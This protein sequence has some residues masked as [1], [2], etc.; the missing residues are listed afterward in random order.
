MARLTFTVGTDGEI[1]LA[2]ATATTVLQVLA[3]TNQRV[4]VL[5]FHVGFDGTNP[6]AEPVQVE[7]LRQTSAGAGRA[8]VTPSKDDDSLPETVQTT[9]TK[10]QAAATEPTAGEIL[11][12]YE[13]HPQA[14][15]E[16]AFGIDEEIRIKGGGRIGLRL[17][18]PS[19]VNCRA[20]LSLEE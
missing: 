5:G 15:Y 19:G 11:R 8:S 6:T 16:R 20:R 9:A 14:S 7:I 18:A 12:E 3:P 4:A 10:W 17:T 2:S 13:V 1:A